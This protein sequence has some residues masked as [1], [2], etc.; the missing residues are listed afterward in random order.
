MIRQQKATGIIRWSFCSSVWRFPKESDLVEPCLSFGKECSLSALEQAPSRFAAT[1]KEY[2]EGLLEE[3]YEKQFMEWI[4]TG[5]IVCEPNYALPDKIGPMKS[6]TTFGKSLYQGEEDTNGFEY[7]MITA[8][9]SLPNV[10]W[11]HRN[12][13]R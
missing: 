9:T 2:I 11:W 4:E 5:E 1:I 3:H 7:D 8:L 6:T 12:I 10:K 13:S